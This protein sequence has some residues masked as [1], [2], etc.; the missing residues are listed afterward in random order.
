[1]HKCNSVL[2]FALCAQAVLVSAHSVPEAPEPTPLDPLLLAFGFNDITPIR[3]QKLAEGM[4]VLFGLGGNILV[5]SGKKRLIIAVM[6][7]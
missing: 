4:Y 2:A 5:S 6:S 7:F 3:T 1:M